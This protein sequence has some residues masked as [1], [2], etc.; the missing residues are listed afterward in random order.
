M[1]VQ[2]QIISPFK[3]HFTLNEARRAY[4]NANKRMVEWEL[5]WNK[6]YVF[7]NCGYK[8]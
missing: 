8:I 4:L 2:I 5:F 6:A 7:V 1:F 3:K